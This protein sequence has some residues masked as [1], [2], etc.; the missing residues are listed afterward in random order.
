MPRSV[1]IF[2]V[3]A[4]LVV[5]SLGAGVMLQKILPPSPDSPA[6]RQAAIRAMAAEDDAFYAELDKLAATE[7]SGAVTSHIF[8]RMHAKPRL[9]A[10]ALDWARDNSVRQ[11]DFSKLNPFYFMLYA[12]LAY[13]GAQAFKDQGMTEGYEDLSKTAF[14]SLLNFD[15]LIATDALR[16]ADT[17]VRDL[18]ASM[19]APRYNLLDYIFEVMTVDEL[20]ELYM[21]LLSAESAM[22]SR[23]P[24]RELCSAG[25]AGKAALLENP[26][27][28][29]KEEDVPN[30]PGT[31]RTILIPPPDFHYEP[32]YIQL[33][34]W[35]TKRAQ[36]QHAVRDSWYQ[37]QLNHEK[38]K[39]D[40]LEIIEELKK[41]L[42]QSQNG[43][44]EPSVDAR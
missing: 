7:S 39:T 31:K 40:A 15:L 9:L 33:E 42:E 12:D 16:C 35:L 13:L 43:T 5:A 36:M 25:A 8:R 20:M 38:R 2:C 30:M 37:R 4:A 28:Q 10:V 27:T 11:E 21:A 29:R 44:P 19:V 32:E 6:A 18:R 24:N 34:E 3:I 1:L 26:G 14:A 22:G 41:S 17:T 23:A